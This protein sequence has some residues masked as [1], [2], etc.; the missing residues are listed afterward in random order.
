MRRKSPLNTLW[1]DQRCPKT[2]EQINSFFRT[3]PNKPNRLQKHKENLLRHQ[4]PH[5]ETFDRWV[6]LNLQS[7][8]NSWQKAKLV[9]PDMTLNNWIPEKRLS[10]FWSF[11]YFLPLEENIICSQSGANVLQLL[12]IKP[13][14][15]M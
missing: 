3:A 14:P 15:G 2:S 13:T 11:E 9:T 7:N 12:F 4:L 8:K 5:W 10:E 1:E 6:P